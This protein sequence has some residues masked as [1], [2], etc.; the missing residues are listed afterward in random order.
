M[1]TYKGKGYVGRQLTV[2]KV[3]SKKTV[4]DFEDNAQLKKGNTQ[5]E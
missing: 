3:R 4:D 2:R 1:D 5:M